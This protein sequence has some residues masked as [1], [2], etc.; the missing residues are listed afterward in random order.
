M[1]TRT[2][3]NSRKKKKEKQKPVLCYLFPQFSLS[4]QKGCFNYLSRENNNLMINE[5]HIME[6]LKSQQC[7]HK[8]TD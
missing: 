3:F 4:T 5:Y 7:R 2:K 1:D 8:F 6:I